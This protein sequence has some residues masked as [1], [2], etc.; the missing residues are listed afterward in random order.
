[1]TTRNFDGG[2][3]IVELFFSAKKLLSLQPRV[4]NRQ[5]RKDNSRC[6]K[7]LS[8]KDDR[9]G[10]THDK[11]LDL[12]SP[13]LIDDLKNSP[14]YTDKTKATTTQSTKFTVSS[15]STPSSLNSPPRD[16]SS[17]AVISPAVSAPTS[18]LTSSL[19]AG[20]NGSSSNLNNLTGKPVECSNCH[21]LNTPLWR[22]DTAGNTLCNACGLFYKLHGTTRPLSLKTDVI[23]KRSSR[24]SAGNSRQSSMT[25]LSSSFANGSFS[26]ISI[27]PNIA[28]S[29]THILSGSLNR[30]QGIKF[31]PIY[32]NGG[33]SLQSPSTFSNS[34]P[35]SASLARHK[36]VL[37]LPKPSVGSPATP[38]ARLIPIP[39][40]GSQQNLV[41]SPSSPYSN[42]PFKRKKSDHNL[43]GSG[44]EY[45]DFGKRTGS[46][47][48]KRGSVGRSSSHS[49]LHL[50]QQQS[51]QVPNTPISFPRKQSNNDSLTMSNINLLNQRYTP[52]SYFDSPQQTDLSRHSSATT[53]NG[54]PHSVGVPTGASTPGLNGSFSNR[55]LFVSIPD[56]RQ[57][58]AESQSKLQNQNH[59]FTQRQHHFSSQF[60]ETSP[61]TPMNV[62]DLLPSS[63]GADTDMDL[64]LKSLNGN[65]MMHNNYFKFQPSGTINTSSLSNGLKK[66]MEMRESPQK[67]AETRD[68]DWLKFEL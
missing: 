29:N 11:V 60:S 30:T 68:L 48:M 54:I 61:D 23:K 14:P 42:Q 12:L 55:Q 46:L 36:N 62:V 3:S 10:H 9:K 58:E 28:A 53:L 39:R 66:Q 67:Q 16:K 65:D 43:V 15:V 47:T 24:R 27:P 40:N 18:N 56:Y 64:D 31:N 32:S 52:N 26:A 2:P 63:V 33:L 25:S 34:L 1:M 7:S 19:R 20:S 59:Q 8:R 41:M 6:Q 57:E 5:L 21:T 13:L 51:L 50:L 22:K 44:T 35:T 38:G 4:Q 45:Y 37:I 17:P 49:S